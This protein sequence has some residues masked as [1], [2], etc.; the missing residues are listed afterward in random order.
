MRISPV[1]IGCVLLGVACAPTYVIRPAD[2]G[3]VGAN[4]AGGLTLYADAN[5]WQ[6]QPEDLAEYLVP[7]WIDIANES[8]NDTRVNYAD[9][10]LLDSRGFRY[11]AI[12]PYT[13]ELV[14]E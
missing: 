2:G 3:N 4:A 1:L 13:G 12:N 5:A 7:I 9:F 8:Q 6:G 14:L 11:A 10:A